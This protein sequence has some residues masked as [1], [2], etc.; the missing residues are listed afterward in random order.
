M[1]LLYVWIEDFR[2]ITDKGYNF[3]NQYEI[4]YD[5]DSNEISIKGI[6]GDEVLEVKNENLS[7]IK[8]DTYYLKDFFGPTISQIT[9]IIGKN[10]SGKSNLLDFIL[11]AISRGARNKLRKNYVLIFKKDD[12]PLFFGKTEGK[13]V[14]NSSVK[15]K[16]LEL[17]KTRPEKN[18]ET[19]FYSN[20]A[21]KRE[22]LFEGSTTYDFSLES[23]NK[24]QSNKIKFIHSEAFT[25]AEESLGLKDN[26]NK[27]IRFVFNP[28]AFIELF[29]QRNNRKLERIISGI[30]MR[31]NKAIYTESEQNYN[32]FKYS[33]AIN[34]LSFL[35][36]NE[37]DISD[38]T[39]VIEWGQQDGHAEAIATLNPKVLDFLINFNDFSQLEGLSNSD[40]EKYKDLLGGLDK[41]SINLG[42]KESFNKSIIVDLNDEFKNLIENISDL[43]NNAQL[44]SHDW[45][46]LSSGM[47]AYLNLFS[48][49]YYLSENIRASSK[50]ILI[51][52]DEGDLYLHPEWQRKFIKNFID[53]VSKTFNGLKVQVILTSH[54][55][56]LISD[57]PKEN[58][59][60][61]DDSGTPNRQ[62]LDA[63]SFGA[64]IHQLFTNQFFLNEGSI[65]EFAK[66]KIR[67]L[68]KELPNMIEE[69]VDLYKKRIEMIGEPIL[70]YRLEE[71]FKE[72]IKELSIERQIEWH[73]QQIV[74]LRTT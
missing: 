70:R 50:N 48:Q 58:V 18:W 74:K 45:S 5:K 11:T 62:L 67:K 56:F 35:I 23:I 3:S 52:I 26:E 55:P 44:I 14:R 25:E 54:S 43:F 6:N 13:S 37:T 8:D 73:Q 71:K 36:I 22:Y 12:S 39:N 32:R 49:L 10:S 47:R 53:F 2:G 61:L 57:L 46:Q 66:I 63:S 15:Y 19:M 27:K 28:N 29:E 17:N 34:L 64:N 20:V 4:K 33:L 65:G 38:L 68:L 30:L 72:R 16:K 7:F 42:E 41:K 21:D 31:Y 9:A 69:N 24:L 1:E 59:I 60:L 40:Y 51:C